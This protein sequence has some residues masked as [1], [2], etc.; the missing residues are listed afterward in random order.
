MLIQICVPTRTV[1]TILLQ[2]LCNQIDFKIQTEI[3]WISANQN[4]EL[5][6]AI[7]FICWWKSNKN[8]SA[9]KYYV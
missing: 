2:L 1:V 6:N 8:T 7:Y 5:Q 3:E 9:N 4:D